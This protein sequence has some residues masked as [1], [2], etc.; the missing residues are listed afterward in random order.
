M[1]AA[2]LLLPVVLSAVIVFIAS[3][4]IWMVA[5]HHKNEWH[6][7]PNEEAV[8]ATLNAQ[9]P[10]PGLY[11]IPFAGT[12]EA[13]KDPAFTRKL[14]EGP[15]AFLNLVR[16]RPVAMGPMLIQSIIFYLVVSYIIAYLAS[17][18]LAPG[19][20][21]LQVFRVTGTAGWL[22]YGF[23]TVSDSIWFGRPWSSTFKGLVDALIYG[24]LTA[25]MFGWL[26]PK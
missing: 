23:A 20:P 22:A 13:R 26:W 18:T 2:S 4:L 11:M 14:Q 1:I 24:C 8:R 15:V 9:K 17:R 21:Y 7:L 6:G 19:T 16:S 5:P 3:A 12:T 10:A 25:G